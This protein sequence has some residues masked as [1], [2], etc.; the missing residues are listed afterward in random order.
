MKKLLAI[1]LV[2]LPCW[3]WA[4]SAV[5]TYNGVADSSVKTVVGVATASAKTANGVDYNDGDSVSSFEISETFADLTN[6]TTTSGSPSVSGGCTATGTY[7]AKNN[8]T[9]SNSA[10][11]YA[12][13]KVTWGDTGGSLQFFLRAA[14]DG[15]SG[16]AFVFF[17][18]LKVG[19]YTTSGWAYNSQL[20]ASTD[21]GATTG[22]WIGVEVVGT[23]AST[24]FSV[25]QW[26]S[27][28]GEKSSW[29]AANIINGT[30]VS[31]T[32]ANSGTVIGFRSGETY[33]TICDLSVGSASE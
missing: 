33:F 26:D 25:W 22:D 28:P 27:D 19:V 1:L 8:T 17:S 7:S 12:K 18:T 10:R 11:Q 24:T 16:Y 29:G 2:F 20:I 30:T 21:S 3:C 32:H 31:T 4:A 9:L 13:Y 14:S 15:N 6:W 23:G 5:K